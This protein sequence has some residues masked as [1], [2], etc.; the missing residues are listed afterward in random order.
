MLDA[1][2]A[3]AWHWEKVGTELNAMR[4]KTLLAEVH[5]LMG[6]GESARALSEQVRKYFLVR[7][8]DDWEIAFVHTIHA[9]ASSAAG[10]LEEHRDSY[11]EAKKAID[12][13]SDEEDRRIVLQ[14]FDQVPEP[15]STSE[16]L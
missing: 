4:A 7:Q 2:H 13:I 14:T 5:A 11:L 12:A 15:V 9:H 1:A 6:F 10:L 8:T 16:A 3:A